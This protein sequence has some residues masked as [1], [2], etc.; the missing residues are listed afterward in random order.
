MKKLTLLGFGLATV[1]MAACSGTGSGG[2]GDTA[3]TATTVADGMD[4]TIE[5]ESGA[6]QAD[7]DFAKEAANGGMAEVAL[8]KLAQ[9]KATDSK[10]KE[11]AVMMVTDHTKAN[12]E[13]K[14]LASS[15][16]IELPTVPS[17]DKQQAEEKLSAMSGAEFDKAYITQMV[18]DHK[19]TV[20]LFE[21]ASTSVKD[22]ELKSFIDKTLPTLKT[23]LEHSERLQK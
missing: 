14:A 22:A 20:A 17:E 5:Q 8:G 11:F 18:E 21:T 15:K 13:L 19:K 16:N 9:K 4:N 2:S 3:D 12:D 6:S 1:M 7:L 23:H 10:V